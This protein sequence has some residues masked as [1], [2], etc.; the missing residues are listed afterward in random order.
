MS[1]Y[2]YAVKVAGD[3]KITLA[4]SEHDDYKW[5]KPSEAMSFFKHQS[6]KDALQELLN[7]I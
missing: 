1:E 7:L 3:E 4:P 5:L 2:V 6:S